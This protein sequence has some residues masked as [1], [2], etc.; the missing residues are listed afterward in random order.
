MDDP[1][2]PGFLLLGERLRR[3]AGPLGNHMAPAG[4]DVVVKPPVKP[5][6]G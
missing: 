3:H 6:S 1:L 4:L 2:P 5:E